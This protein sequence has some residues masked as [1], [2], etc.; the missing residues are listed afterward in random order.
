M[1]FEILRAVAVA[2]LLAFG[3][4]GAAMAEGASA[5]AHAMTAESGIAQIG[6]IA[7]SG[8]FARAMPPGAPTG[9]AY[10]NIANKGK[11]DDV[12]VGVS[13]PNGMVE[14]HQ[15]SMQGG[16]M[17]MSPVAGGLAIPAGETVQLK[18]G[19]YHLMF[20]NV[21]TPLKE[22]ETV[23]VTLKFQTAG[24]VTLAL[25]VAA[26]GASAPMAM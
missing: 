26:V 19:G 2:G 21:T 15:M 22:G 7:I 5:S 11:N 6:D 14:V 9:S 10:L 23:E 1:K 18:P 12:L 4:A 24:E 20:M 16:M 8:G 25:P 13:S 3:S 17:K